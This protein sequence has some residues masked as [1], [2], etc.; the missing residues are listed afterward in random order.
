LK[1][2]LTRIQQRID[3]CRDKAGFGHRFAERLPSKTSD[4]PR[5][6]S[7]VVLGNQHWDQRSQHQRRHRR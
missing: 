1:E 6:W 5:R 4:N 7:C 2:M 3:R